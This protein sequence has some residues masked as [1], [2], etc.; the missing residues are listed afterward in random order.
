VARVAEVLLLAVKKVTLV[1]DATLHGPKCK[2]RH[3]RTQF[4]ETMIR[5]WQANTIALRAQHPLDSAS[6]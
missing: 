3:A 4:V 1:K 2:V 5:L 6:L